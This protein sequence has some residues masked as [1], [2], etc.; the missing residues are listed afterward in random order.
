[1]SLDTLKLKPVPPLVSQY[2][3]HCVS[4]RRAFTDLSEGKIWSTYPR[5]FIN[6]QNKQN[7]Q[8]CRLFIYSLSGKPSIC[9]KCKQPQSP[10]L[11][12]LHFAQNCFDTLGALGQFHLCYASH[13]TAIPQDASG[14]FA[15]SISM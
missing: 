15:I 1:M 6:Y 8:L 9:Q 11:P 7:S 5:N 2:R 3:F 4:K 12:L 10:L 14:H 13:L